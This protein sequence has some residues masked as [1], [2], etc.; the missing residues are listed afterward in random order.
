LEKEYQATV[1]KVSSSDWFKIGIENNWISSKKTVAISAMDMPFPSASG[2]II[3]SARDYVREKNKPDSGSE[4]SKEDSGSSL[5]SVLGITVGSIAAQN[6]VSNLMS[7]SQIKMT[8]EQINSIASDPKKLKDLLSSRGITSVDQLA[9]FQEKPSLFR[10]MVGPSK[11]RTALGRGAAALGGGAAGW[12]LTDW[13]TDATVNQRKGFNVASKSAIEQKAG[14]IP[15]FKGAGLKLTMI[16]RE[17]SGISKSL[18]KTM[19]EGVATFLD[20]LN[21]IDSQKIQ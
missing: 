4:S 3:D 14:S 13:I 20:L 19:A 18:D 15:K 9:V 8:P 16:A 12:L 17:V 21:Q 11:T 2:G 6:I 1:I 10:R 7:R 5:N